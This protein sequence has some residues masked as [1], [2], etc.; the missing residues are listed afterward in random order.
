MLLTEVN[1]LNIKHIFHEVDFQLTTNTNKRMF[2][3]I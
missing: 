2:F 1:L 3:K